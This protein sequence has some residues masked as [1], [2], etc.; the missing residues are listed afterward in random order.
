M[1]DLSLE[2]LGPQQ[3]VEKVD[4]EGHGNQSGN[5]VV[6]DFSLDDFSSE[7]FAGAGE[8]P[9]DHEEGHEQKAVSDVRHD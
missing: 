9:G 5:C 7:L 8:I 6:H 4:A 1:R 3:R 2:P